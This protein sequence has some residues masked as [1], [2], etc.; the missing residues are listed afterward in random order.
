MWLRI[1]KRGGFY[2]LFNSTDGQSFNPAKV[3]L[4][5]RLTADNT[6]PCLSAPLQYIGVFADNGTSYGAPQVDASFDFFEFKVLPKKQ[7]TP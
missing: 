4:P 6:V 1:I 2:E 7:E 3:I 5:A